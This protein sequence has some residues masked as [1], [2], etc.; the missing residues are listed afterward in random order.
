MASTMK[1]ITIDHTRHIDRGD[2]VHVMP[3]WREGEAC[4][5]TP[6]LRSSAQLTGL[7][8]TSNIDTLLSDQHGEGHRRPA[9]HRGLKRK[10]P[11]ANARTHP[12]PWL[13]DAPGDATRSL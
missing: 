6:T 2:I 4:C 11:I 7:L 5:A 10:S 3:H 8:V 12:W 9:A 1:V 13:D